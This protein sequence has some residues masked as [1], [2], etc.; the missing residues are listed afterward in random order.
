M[1]RNRIDRTSHKISCEEFSRMQK[2]EVEKY[3]DFMLLS[4]E[5]FDKTKLFQFDIT[6]F[7]T[8][9]KSHGFEVQRTVIDTNPIPERHFVYISH[10]RS[11]EETIRKSLSLPKSVADKFDK[12]FTDEEG[13]QKVSQLEQAKIVAKLFNEFLDQVIKEQKDGTLAVRYEVQ[14]N[15]TLI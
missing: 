6:K 1:S 2:Y 13:K 14:E 3:K 11:E 7:N 10:K 9:M 5:E 12:L 4:K 15:Y 8:I